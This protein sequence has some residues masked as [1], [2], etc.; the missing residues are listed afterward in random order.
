MNTRYTPSSRAPGPGFH[1][2]ARFVRD[3]RPV[4]E[5]SLPRAAGVLAANAP[6]RPGATARLTEPRGAGVRWLDWLGER[7]GS[8][9]GGTAFA[10]TATDDTLAELVRLYNARRHGVGDSLPPPGARVVIKVAQRGRDDDRAAW[11]GDQ[12]R[13]AVAQDALAR[14][15]C[16]RVSGASRGLCAKDHVPRLFLAGLVLDAASASECFV[17][18]MALAPGATLDSFLR[19]GGAL[20]ADAYLKVER[21][22]AA[23][24]AHGLAHGD[25]HRKNV[26]WD[27]PTG[28]AT[29]VD[30]GFAVVLPD[31]LTAE[32]RAAMKAAALRGARSLGEVWREPARSAV[33]TRAQ[34]YLNR[35]AQARLGPSFGR[36][37]VWYNPDGNALLRLYDR[38]DPAE[39]AAVPA[40]RLALWGFSPPAPPAPPAPRARRES[41]GRDRRRDERRRDERRRNERRRDERPRSK[42]RG[43]SASRTPTDRKRRR[44]S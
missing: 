10:T 29:L 30:F 25:L 36:H 20:T 33:G 11:L 16:V 24:W 14:A 18:V 9:K 40:R 35:V 5:R 43:R 23:V 28:T 37:P 15:G 7:L 2:E 42:R 3:T 27:A 19:K 8:G 41:P 34:S 22:A 32:L 44:N 1:E 31:D 17:T 38:L 21:A 26:M 6:R 39:K 4:S 12:V 13:E